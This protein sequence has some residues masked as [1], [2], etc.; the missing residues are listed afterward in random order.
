VVLACFNDT[1]GD[2]SEHPAAHDLQLEGI[3]LNLDICSL[4][5]TRDRLIDVL[6]DLIFDKQTVLVRKH[7]YFI[8]LLNGSKHFFDFRCLK[9]F[10]KHFNLL[11]GE[12]PSLWPLEDYLVRRLWAF[13]LIAKLGGVDFK[14]Q[15]LL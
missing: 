1:A 7:L 11:R 12:L 14:D 8:R 2:L 4:L 5:G 15:L 13:Q 9:K 3:K 6:N 10:A